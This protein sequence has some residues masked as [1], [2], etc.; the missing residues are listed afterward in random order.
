MGIFRIRL[1]GTGSLLVFWMKPYNTNGQRD[2]EGNIVPLF[3]VVEIA[4]NYESSTD[5]K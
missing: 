2:R 3:T 4:K 5:A 1:V